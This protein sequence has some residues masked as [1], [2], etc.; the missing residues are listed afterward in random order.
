MDEK[1][2]IV[3]ETLD[4]IGAKQKRYYVFNKIDMIDKSMDELL[5]FIAN[6]SYHEDAFLISAHAGL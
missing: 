5:S 6:K 3:E 2:S 1:I 4:K